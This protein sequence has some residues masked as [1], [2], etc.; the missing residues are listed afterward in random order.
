MTPSSV[1]QAVAL[2]LLPSVA[3]FCPQMAQQRLRAFWPSCLGERKTFP[4]SVDV[5]AKGSTLGFVLSSFV[6]DPFKAGTRNSRLRGSGSIFRLKAA[7][8][9]SV[10][11]FG[12]C[13]VTTAGSACPLRCTPHAR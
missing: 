2:L 10:A 11:V 4:C 9:C 8:F 1:T 7:C 13:V 12:L 6:L 5:L 3:Q